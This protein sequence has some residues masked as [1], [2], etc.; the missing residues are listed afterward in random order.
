[1][2]QVL[3]SPSP[4]SPLVDLLPLSLGPETLKEIEPPT[5]GDMGVA[6]E[7]ETE[8]VYDNIPGDQ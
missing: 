7:R 2:E 8:G 5:G 6:K 3:S 1:M 4:V